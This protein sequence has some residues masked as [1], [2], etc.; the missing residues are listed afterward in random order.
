MKSSERPSPRW[1][2]SHR[3]GFTLI[4]VVFAL[5]VLGGSLVVLLGLQSSLITRTLRDETQERAILLTRELLAPLEAEVSSADDIEVNGKFREVYDKVVKEPGSALDLTPLDE[6]FEV[7]YQVAPWKV[8]G[9][10]EESMKKVTV[11]VA[12]GPNLD[13][14]TTT[15]FFVPVVK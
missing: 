6:S 12:W 5:V 9:I 13:E 3:N 10:D 2:L 8:K 4:E 7:S 15:N 14:R 1:P 11:V